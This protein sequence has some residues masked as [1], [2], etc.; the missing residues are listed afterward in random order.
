MNWEPCLLRCLKFNENPRLM[1]KS[2][3]H[4]R[5]NIENCP[6]AS[7][8]TCIY[9]YKPESTYQLQTSICY[10]NVKHDYMTFL[11]CIY[12]GSS[13]NHIQ[14]NSHDHWICEY[15]AVAGKPQV[16]LFLETHHNFIKIATCNFLCS[17]FALQNIAK[18]FTIQT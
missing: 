4:T 8:C 6:L 16:R 3:I 13:L 15:L 17:L 7:T 5:D 11:W 12:S 2:E 14:S 9:R 18:Y 10:F 1:K